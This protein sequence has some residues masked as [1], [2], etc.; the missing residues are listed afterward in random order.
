MVAAVDPTIELQEAAGVRRGKSI[1][2]IEIVRFLYREGVGILHETV[3]GCGLDARQR[4]Q[5]ETNCISREVLFHFGLGRWGLLRKRNTVP[6]PARSEPA[7]KRL[8]PL[9]QKR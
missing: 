5:G 3:S 9:Q 4:K 8:F 2:D 1:R 7:G 6:E